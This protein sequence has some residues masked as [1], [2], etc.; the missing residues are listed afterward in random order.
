MGRWFVVYAHI[1][2][3]CRN[4]LEPHP[5]LEPLIDLGFEITIMPLECT[6]PMENVRY[7]VNDC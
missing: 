6:L 2:L 4:N 1:A 7:D 3:T 5:S